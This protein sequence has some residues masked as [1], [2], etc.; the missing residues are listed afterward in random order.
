ML[1]E[2]TIRNYQDLYLK[3]GIPELLKNHHQGEYCRMSDE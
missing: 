1:D 2:D 3:G